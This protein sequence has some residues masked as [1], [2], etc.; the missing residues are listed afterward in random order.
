MAVH[1]GKLV[2]FRRRSKQQ[3]RWT[4]IH[5]YPQQQRFSAHIWQFKL[6]EH[7]GTPFFSSYSNHLCYNICISGRIKGEKN[8]A[9]SYL[10]IRSDGYRIEPKEWRWRR[11]KRRQE[12]NDGVA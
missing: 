5:A 12:L 10:W 6:I 11:R 2:E 4:S 9:S 3:Q 8:V 1:A 7:S